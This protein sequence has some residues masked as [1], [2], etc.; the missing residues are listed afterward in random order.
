MVNFIICDK[1]QYIALK[2]SHNKDDLDSINPKA[3]SWQILHSH[4]IS[5]DPLLLKL[6]PTAAKVLWGYSAEESILS[7]CDDLS[8]NELK[9][10]LL[11]LQALYKEACNKKALSGFHGDFGACI[12]GSPVY[13]LYLC[14][15]V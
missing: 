11:L 13:L 14:I 5:E 4:Y 9:K 2:G 3:A 6:S 12:D 7:E 1:E 15:T 8:I 10:V